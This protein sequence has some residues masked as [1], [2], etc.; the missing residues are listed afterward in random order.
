M[1]KAWLNGSFSRPLFQ[2]DAA[3]RRLKACCA[4]PAPGK[5]AAAPELLISAVWLSFPVSAVPTLAQVVE[6]GPRTPVRVNNRAR[7]K[8][9]ALRPAGGRDAD[10]IGAQRHRQL[11]DAAETWRNCFLRHS[12]AAAISANADRAAMSVPS[13][14]R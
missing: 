9:R 14:A 12:A 6:R 10:K 4:K 5:A 8:F 1:H 11:V 7:N 13:R 3:M 2:L